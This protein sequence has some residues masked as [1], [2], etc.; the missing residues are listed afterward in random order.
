MT[1]LHEAVTTHL[2]TDP[3]INRVPTAYRTTPL[4]THV[5]D[6]R[7]GAAPE[8]DPDL[9]LTIE[10]QIGKELVYLFILHPEDPIAPVTTYAGGPRLKNAAYWTMQANARDN[11]ALKTLAENARNILDNIITEHGDK[12]DGGWTVFTAGD[13]LTTASPDDFTGDVQ[14]THEIPRP[15][16]GVLDDP[17][18]PERS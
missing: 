16:Y 8:N 12:A 9:R 14:V 15:E 11:D 10:S 18:H 5:G 2:N 4:G 17:A 3:R 13:F 7:A 6:L 1:T